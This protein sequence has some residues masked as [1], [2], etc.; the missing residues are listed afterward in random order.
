MEGKRVLI[1]LNFNIKLSEEEWYEEEE[2]NQDDDEESQ[3]RI[4]KHCE[5]RYVIEANTL[6]QAFPTIRYCI[7]HLAKYVMLIGSMGP[8]AGEYREE[9]NMKP[10]KKWLK[11]QLETKVVYFKEFPIE[12]F[13]EKID[14]LPENILI[15][16]ENTAFCPEEFGY[17]VTREGEV[18]KC[19]WDKIIR[20]RE[21][22]T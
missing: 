15:L 5:D 13:E 3:P 14:E 2:E 22:L 19:D 10:V 6:E 18:Y 20:F 17:T 12:E 9:W 11:E 8:R 16:A 4:V 1:R 21:E 7:D